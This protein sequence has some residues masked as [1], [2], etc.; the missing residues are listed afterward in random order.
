MGVFKKPKFLIICGVVLLAVI[1]LTISLIFLLQPKTVGFFGLDREN[2]EAVR[3][4]ALLEDRG[5]TVYYAED[6]EDLENVDCKAWIVR[7]TSDIFA[8]KILERIGDKAIFV[9]CNPSLSQPVR[10]VGWDMEEAGTL[11][12]ELLTRLPN[13]GDTNED[14]T[15]SCLLLTAPEGYKEKAD[16]EQGLYAGLAQ[17]QL[18]YVILDT[19][20]CSL[21]EEAGM[22]ATSQS[23]S[24]Y[25]RDIEIVMVSSE[26]LAAGAAQAISQGG[27]EISEDLYLLAVGHT[28]YSMDALNE[29]QRSGLVFAPWSDFDDLLLDAVADTIDGKS[30]QEYLLPLKLYTNTSALQ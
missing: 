26:V 23:L 12:A 22:E 17:C 9:G 27:W 10:F 30:P 19:L 8:E 5:Y 2:E 29:R 4:Q 1:V 16:W 24:T 20:A 28:D 7:A 14:G 21:T 25:G 18:P 3:L 13:H 15:L 11:L 6:L